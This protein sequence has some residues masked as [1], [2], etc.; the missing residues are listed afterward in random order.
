[1]CERAGVE[2]FVPVPT[3]QIAGRNRYAPLPSDPPEVAARRER[4]NTNDAKAIYKE[5]ATTV[6]CANAYV[7]N[8]GL[9]RFCVRGLEAV[10]ATA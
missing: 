10:K 3:P 4:M 8:Q 1:M 5:R 2:A 7:R 6:E 9:T